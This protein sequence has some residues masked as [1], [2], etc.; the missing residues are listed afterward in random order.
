MLRKRIQELERELLGR[1][2]TRGRPL[3][4]IKLSDSMNF[5][6]KENEVTALNQMASLHLDSDDV[7]NLSQG[8]MQSKL[9]KTPGKKLRKLTPRSNLGLGDEDLPMLEAP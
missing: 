9:P 8:T 4:E 6:D 5:E 2:P 3:R 7:F 1:S